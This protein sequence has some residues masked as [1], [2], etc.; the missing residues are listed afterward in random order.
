MFTEEFFER[1]I[2]DFYTKVD[3]AIRLHGVEAI[4]SQDILYR[5][6]RVATPTVEYSEIKRICSDID[7]APLGP[8]EPSGHR[9]WPFAWERASERYKEIAVNAEKAGHTVTAGLNF[10]RASL[11]AHSGQMFCR[12]EWP[13]MTKLQLE[14]RDS[15]RRAAPYLGIEDHKV[16]YGDFEIPGYLW[17]PK[18]VERPPVVIMAPGANS[19]KEELHRWA[20][21]LVDRNLAAFTFD[22]PG[23]GELSPLQGSK[24]P[25]RLEKYHEVFTTIINYLEANLN[26]KV[27][28]T[29]VAIWGQS[30]GGHLV[31]RAFEHETRPI[32]AVNLAGPPTNEGF[33]FAVGDHLVEMRDLLG[34][35]TFLEAYE[36]LEK[37]GDGSSALKHIKVP[38]LIVYGS[39]DVLMGEDVMHQMA[40][41]IGDNA[42]LLEYKDG[43]HGVFNWDF[44]MTDAMCDWLVD[45]LT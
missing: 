6:S 34:V 33:A 3:H 10:L 35:D 4:G 23:Q 44:V 21:P 17:V 42:M 20:A 13:E 36:Y 25:M 22:G 8:N 19:V 38:F 12:P 39:R 18:D 26:N 24:L 43:N 28:A 32:A 31:T 9:R 5:L 45:H 37:H 29:K 7:A 2:E 1:R 16:P 40:K 41:D 27:D 14:R 11:L 15:Y 30:M